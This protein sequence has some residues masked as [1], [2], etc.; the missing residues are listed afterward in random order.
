MP[1]INVAPVHNLD[2]GTTPAAEP[3]ISETDRARGQGPGTVLHAAAKVAAAVTIAHSL[4]W[5]VV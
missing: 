1:P 3:R 2:L 4:A 5:L